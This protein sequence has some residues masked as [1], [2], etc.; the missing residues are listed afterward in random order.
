MVGRRRAYRTIPTW[1]R[2]DSSIYENMHI[3]KA[4]IITVKAYQSSSNKP[5]A[6]ALATVH[7][8]HMPHPTLT[9]SDPWSE[10][11]ND[12]GVYRKHS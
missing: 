8:A 11:K 5:W 10:N 4:R 3:S 1:P 7:P 9:Y 12:H 2:K 6:R